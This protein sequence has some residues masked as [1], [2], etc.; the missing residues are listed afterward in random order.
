MSTTQQGRTQKI[1]G[2]IFTCLPSC[3]VH[4]DVVDRLSM[5]TCVNAIERFMAQYGDVTRTLHSYN[6]TNFHGVDNAIRNICN[7]IEDQKNQWY[8]RLKRISW[9]FNIILA[10]PQGGAW[11]WL[12]RSVHH[13]LS[14]VPKDP[15]NKTV[16]HDVLRTMLSCTQRILKACL[17][18][19]VSSSIVDCEATSPISLIHSG[20]TLPTNP[21]GV[22]PSKEALASNFKYVHERV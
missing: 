16:N 5:E 7:K 8:Y 2:V 17:L 21:I 14:T 15:Q 1:W 12:I 11:E 19:P 9:Y 20:S 6:G 4:L 18:T 10:S 3:T 22:F 13:L